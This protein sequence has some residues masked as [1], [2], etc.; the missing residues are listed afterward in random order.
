[1]TVLDFDARASDLPP[2]PPVSHA[3]SAWEVKT[4]GHDFRLYV[5]SAS[6]L[7]DIIRDVRQAKRRVW[8]ESFTI[9]AD[10]AGEALADALIERAKA[11]V[12]VRVMYDAVGSLS[13][14]AAFF[15][16]MERGG[17]QVHA[18]HRLSYALRQ[19]ALYRIFNRRN[20]RKLLVVDDTVGYFGGMNLID[21]SGV[22]MVEE[23]HAAGLPVSSGWR[24]VHVRMVGPQ[25]PL[26]ADT[27]DWLW[28]RVDHRR[29][30]RRRWPLKRMLTTDGDSL[31]LFDCS[32]GFK[33]RRA[34]RVLCPLIRQA[35]TSITISMAYFI[36]IG[37]VVRELVRAARRGVKIRVVIPGKSDVRFAEWASRH[38]YL[39]LVRRGIRIFERKDLMLHSKT[40]VIDGRV[41]VI[42][43][44]NL[45]PRSL[46]WNMEFL[47][48]IRSR[49]MGQTLTRIC[50][51][52][53]RNSRRITEAHC[54]RHTFIQ[55]WLHWLAWTFR[56]WL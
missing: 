20:H 35:R 18:F 56:R 17:V 45:D 25:Q 19:F 31:F 36:P 40:L 16:R 24:D 26:I 39:R 55:R 37:A 54:R 11:G 48:V 3:V 52:E 23:A 15:A 7:R 42:G 12:E 22:A 30:K 33:F 5:E 9:A 6:L 4:A 50:A 49:A 51:Y 21:Q 44:C 2:V 13:T 8:L 32:P 53:M 47:A 46:Q 34:K 28:H 1:M 43:S 27:M 38:L 41:S 10:A 29:I 14:P